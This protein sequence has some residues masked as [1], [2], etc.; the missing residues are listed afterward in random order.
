MKLKNYL[1]EKTKGKSCEDKFGEYLF[2]E[3]KRYYGSVKEWDTDIEE[4][5]FLQV[6][7][8]LEGT[9]DRR[10]KSKIVIKAFEDLKACKNKYAKILKDD[11]KLLYRGTILSKKEVS[12]YKYNLFK[13]GMRNAEISTKTYEYKPHSKIQSWST[14]I[15]VAY[16]FAEDTHTIKGTD[17]DQPVI[18]EAKIGSNK[19]L[20]NHK[21]L[22]KMDID[23]GTANESEVIVLTD[24]PIKC[25]IITFDTPSYKRD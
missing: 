12:S 1:S 13:K 25:K 15:K 16:G 24:E 18:L 3:F 22:N 23:I 21:F 11:A 2:G 14:D 8:F 7:N 19:T 4:K 6:Q 20:F 10:G 17:K 5:I 9:Y